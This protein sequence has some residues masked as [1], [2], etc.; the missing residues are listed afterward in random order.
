MADGTAEEQG[1]RRPRQ[2]KANSDRKTASLSVGTCWAGVPF[3]PLR[4]FPRASLLDLIVPCIFS[5]FSYS[6]IQLTRSSHCYHKKDQILSYQSL[7][8]K[9][10]ELLVVSLLPLFDAAPGSGLY[11]L[12]GV[13]EKDACSC[14]FFVLQ[15]RQVTYPMARLKLVSIRNCI[16]RSHFSFFLRDAHCINSQCRKSYL[17]LILDAFVPIKVGLVIF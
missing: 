11:L 15:Q 3:F 13:K 1:E 7:N 12:L 10:I 2:P 4:F 14:L 5:L 16:L 8:K 17:V 6:T 9:Q